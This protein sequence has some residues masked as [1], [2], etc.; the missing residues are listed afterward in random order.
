MMQCVRNLLLPNRNREL[1]LARYELWKRQLNQL[2]SHH[3][4][5]GY[6]DDVIIRHYF[7]LRAR[8][9]SIDE[10]GGF[11]KG[12]CAHP[13]VCLGAQEGVNTTS[14]EKDREKT[15]ANEEREQAAMWSVGER[16]D[17][18]V[19]TRAPRKLRKRDGRSALPV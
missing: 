15:V 4:A 17:V 7:C 5:I 16:H 9:A 6:K 14:K 12:L 11:L 19:K 18:C 1:E 3:F 10:D 13:C 8:L 2:F